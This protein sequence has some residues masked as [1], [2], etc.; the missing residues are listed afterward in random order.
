MGADSF[1]QV[2]AAVDTQRCSDSGRA[3]GEHLGLAVVEWPL[4]TAR[5]VGYRSEEEPDHRRLLVSV[6]SGVFVFCMVDDGVLLCPC[7][8]YQTYD[9]LQNK[10]KPFIVQA[11]DEKE[12]TYEV[13]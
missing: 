12:T 1:C 6:P 10:D 7:S 9:G 3:A 5:A 2:M 8:R 13:S 11:E 4:Q